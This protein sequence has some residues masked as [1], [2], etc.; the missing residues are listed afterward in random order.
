MDDFA[1][2]VGI[3]ATG[4]ITINIFLIKSIANLCERLARL[5]GKLYSKACVTFE[6]RI[7]YITHTPAFLMETELIA[8]TGVLVIGIGMLLKVGTHASNR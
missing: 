8:L 5:E 6:A 4:S 7:R 3:L 2:L 1:V